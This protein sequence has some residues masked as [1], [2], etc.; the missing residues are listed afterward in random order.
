MDNMSGCECTRRPCGVNGDIHIGREME[1]LLSDTTYHNTLLHE[2]K[3][4]P[5]VYGIALAFATIIAEFHSWP[6]VM[7]SILFR[8]A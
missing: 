3:I 6:S 7:L 1:L 2:G 8:L 5:K 4:M